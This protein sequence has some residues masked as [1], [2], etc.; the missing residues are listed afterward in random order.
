MMF[1]KF[2]SSDFLPIVLSTNTSRTGVV[3]QAVAGACD[4]ALVEDAG[5]N[6]LHLKTLYTSIKGDG[7]GGVV[8]FTTNGS[9]TIDICCF[10]SIS[11]I[12][13]YLC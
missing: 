4:V 10:Y 8:K 7:T 1:L 2:L 11:W 5:S 3:A 6:F 13:L 9:G 12:R